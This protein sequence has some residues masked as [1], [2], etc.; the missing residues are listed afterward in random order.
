ML[1][2]VTTS[3]TEKKDD[4]NTFPSVLRCGLNP[5][6][7]DVA[8]TQSGGTNWNRLIDA[9]DISLAETSP[10]SI[11][12]EGEKVGGKAGECH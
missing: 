11:G 9:T 12:I 1:F 2:S 5:T 4:E 6:G 3:K 10:E 7:I 8:R